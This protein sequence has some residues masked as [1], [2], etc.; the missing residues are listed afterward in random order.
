METLVWED[1]PAS[2]D[3]EVFEYPLEPYSW[4]QSRGNAIGVNAQLDRFEELTRKQTLQILGPGFVSQLEAE[5]EEQYYDEV[6]C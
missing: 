6:Y 2:F 1:Y 3:I 5:A 4:G